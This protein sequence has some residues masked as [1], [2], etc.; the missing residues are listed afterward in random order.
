M[1]S[2]KL[3]ALAF[4]PARV[5]AAAVFCFATVAAADAATLT[6]STAVSQA[7]TTTN[8]HRA[9]SVADQAGND[10]VY[11]GY[12]QTT[13][14]NRRRVNQHSTNSPYALLNQQLSA[15]SE[16]PKGIATDDRGNVFVSYRNS[17][18]TNS[19]IQSFTSTLTT[20]GSVT[21]NVSPTVGG[22]AIQKSGANY[23]AYTVF[24]SGGLIHRYDVTNPNSMFLDTTFGSGGS[25]NVPGASNLRGI[26]VGADGSLYIA[27]RD[28]ANTPNP[29]GRVYKVSADLSTTSFVQ[30]TR[31][32]DV[33]I[34]CEHLYASS[35]NGA[36]SLIRVMNLS[37]LS[38][39]E[40]ITIATLDGNPYSRGSNEGWSGIDIDSIGRIW[41]ADQHYGNTGGTQDRLLVS[42]ALPPCIPEPGTMVL[43]GIALFAFVG[44][45]RYRR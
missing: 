5:L 6:W 39:V 25:Y 34:Y 7:S 31:A 40:D 12:I 14:S 30:L 44:S 9:V 16:Q 1:K 18:N 35:Y 27:A 3:T 29:A 41:L 42:S 43:A 37:D 45:A 26:E 13:G 24:E 28:D 2:T 10:S 20:T 19:Y 23:Y 4:N 22:I 8:Q 36:N 21:P 32:M 17:G 33:A 11:I 38:T 15:N